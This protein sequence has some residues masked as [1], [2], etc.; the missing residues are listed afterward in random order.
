MSDDNAPEA[1]TATDAPENTTAAETPGASEPKTFD[2]DYVRKLRDEAA[3]Y[4]TEAKANAK[5]LEDLEKQAMT[6]TEKAI[7]QAKA[8]AR[9]E[10]LGEV[11]S[12]LV[13]AEVR[14][15]A[16]GRTV[17]VEA[18]LEGL[19]RRRFLTDDGDADRDAIGGWI[20]RVAPKGDPAKPSPIDMGQ[21]T[22][23]T[24]NPG[25]LT[26]A[27]IKNM[28]PKQIQAALKEGRLDNLLTGR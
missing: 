3:K 22:R 25:Q 24:N 14:A 18:L 23:P 13:D 4:R 27:A 2:E 9:S 28:T 17:D 20:D 26:E 16:A 5:R 10:V 1:T 7:A 6:D 8:D 19:D 11:G 21:G 15:A 12:K